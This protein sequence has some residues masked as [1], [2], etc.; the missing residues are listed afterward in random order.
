M[1]REEWKAK[2]ESILENDYDPEGLIDGLSDIIEDE[3]RKQ[4]HSAVISCLESV[5]DGLRHASM[6]YYVSTK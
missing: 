4:T 2:L 1:T 5:I 6:D 3:K